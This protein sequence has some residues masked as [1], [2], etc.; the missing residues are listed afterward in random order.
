MVINDKLKQFMEVAHGMAIGTRD[1]GLAPTYNRAL[2]AKA[3]DD[4][5]VKVNIAKAIAGRAIDNLEDNKRITMVQVD[6]LTF[7]CYQFKGSFIRAYDGSPED[8]VLVT[9]YMGRM[10]EVAKRIGMDDKLLVKIPQDPI[11]AIEFEVEQ[12]FEQT[13]KKGTGK[14]IEA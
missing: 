10:T 5:T 12:I 8:K 4:N 6:F 14:P 7:E 11:I 1:A 3:L 9:E 13:P 2:G